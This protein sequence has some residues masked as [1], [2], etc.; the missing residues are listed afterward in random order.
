MPSYFQRLFFL[1]S[2]TLRFARRDI[3]FLIQFVDTILREACLDKPPIKKSH[4]IT[5]ITPRLQE[6]FQTSRNTIA[7]LQAPELARYERGLMPRTTCSRINDSYLSIFDL[8]AGRVLVVW[9]TDLPGYGNWQTPT[10]HLV[11]PNEYVGG[12]GRGVSSIASL[13]KANSPLNLS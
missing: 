3:I 4:A 10:H 12:V 6:R 5:S 7:H 11:L 13:F 8:M 1:L 9:A 2:I